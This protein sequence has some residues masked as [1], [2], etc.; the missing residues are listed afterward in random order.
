MTPLFPSRTNRSISR[1]GRRGFTLIELLVS[2]VAGLIVGLAVVSLSKNVANQF[3]E[4]VRAN[5]AET[6][7][8]LA[9]QR[10]RS[11]ISRA[12]LMTTGNIFSDPRTSHAPGGN[13]AKGLLPLQHLTGIRIVSSGS[14]VP[15]TT[16]GLGSAPVPPAAFGTAAAAQA[17]VLTPDAFAVYGNLTSGDEYFGSVDQGAPGGC[18]G[19]VLRLNL[20]DPSLLRILRDSTGALVPVAQAESAL[21]Q[22]FA[23]IAGHAFYARVTDTKGF[24]HYS[25]T[26]LVPATWD[27]TNAYVYLQDPKATLTSLETS[28]QFGGVDGFETVS[29][30]PIQG[31]YWYV[32]RVTAGSLGVAGALVENAA[33]VSLS[34]QKF[35]LYRAWISADGSGTILTND[36]EVVAEFA[37]DLKL[38]FTV[39]DPAQPEASPAKALVLGF[40]SLPSDKDPWANRDITTAAPSVPGR[41]SQGPHRIRSV[42]YRFTTRAATPDR[43]QALAPPPG[44]DFLYRYRI[45]ALYARARV[46][47][48]EVALVN[49]A[50]MN[51]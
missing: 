40:A 13:G 6:S 50:R 22:M 15:Q 29:V 47:Q 23:P 44:S 17:P 31:A 30:S 46:T 42:R 25:A 32:G 51:Y 48:G 1:R 33:N 5:S 34:T 21:A 7:V 16:Y 38:G 49:Q 27:G 11:D 2:L 36:S 8:R 24:Y 9:S 4:E 37:V 20:D 43:D 18:G 39:D 45:G 10:L 41:G 12:G 3:Y 14:L 26:C 28:S 19:K 35:D